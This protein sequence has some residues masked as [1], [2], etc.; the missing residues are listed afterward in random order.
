[1]VEAYRTPKAPKIVDDAPVMEVI[2]EPNLHKIPVLTHYERD[3]GPYITSVVISARSCD[4]SVE[5]VS[6]HRLLVL[7]EKHLAIRLVPRQ[8]HRLRTMAKAS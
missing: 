6:I 5:N 2:E 4:G 7:D 8:L 3:A 1:M